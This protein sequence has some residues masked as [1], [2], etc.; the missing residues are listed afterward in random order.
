MLEQIDRPGAL[1]SEPLAMTQR[2]VPSTVLLNLEKVP[3]ARAANHKEIAATRQV[4]LQIRAAAG[5]TR[6][7]PGMVGPTAGL[8][9]IRRLP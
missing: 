4:T 6:L 1:V 3:S 8:V 2:A 5:T 7:D 9:L